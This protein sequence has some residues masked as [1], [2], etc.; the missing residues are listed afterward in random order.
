MW[1]GCKVFPQG[2]LLLHRTRT[3]QLKQHVP[4][5]VTKGWDRFT[6]LCM[7]APMS[8]GLQRISRFFSCAYLRLC[9]SIS[10]YHSRTFK[11]YKSSNIIQMFLFFYTCCKKKRKKKEHARSSDVPPL[12]WRVHIGLCDLVRG[13]LW[14]AT[15]VSP[16]SL[17]EMQILRPLPDLLN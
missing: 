13:I 16:G 5:S 10:E 17:S 8:P 2:A 6:F 9:T 4:R 15:S 1:K 3:Q 12:A 11:D 7:R 14:P